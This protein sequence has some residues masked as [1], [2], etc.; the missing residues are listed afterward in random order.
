MLCDSR[1]GKEKRNEIA[2]MIEDWFIHNN[3]SL[4]SMQ[5]LGGAMWYNVCVWMWWFNCCSC[6]HLT[7]K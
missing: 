1:F 5:S 7:N 2:I 3:V 4:C 6:S